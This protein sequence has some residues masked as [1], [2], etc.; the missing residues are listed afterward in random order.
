MTQDTFTSF[1]EDTETTSKPTT[2][3]NKK[4]KTTQYGLEYDGSV[5]GMY[6]LFLLDLFMRIITLGIYFFWG[7]TRLRKHVATHHSLGGDRFEYTGTGGELFKGFLKVLPILVILFAPILLAEFYPIL[8][9]FY[10]PL[11]YCW[12]IA[13]YGASRYRYSRLRWRGIRGFLDGSTIGYANLAFKRM[14]LNVITLG[15]TKPASDIAKY[16]YIANNT[17]FGSIK[18]EYN[19]NSK[20]LFGAY[21]MSGL[22]IIVCF[23]FILGIIGLSMGSV[24]NFLNPAMLGVIIVL[25]IIATS[26]V[27]PIARAIYTA[28]LMREKMRGLKIGQLRFMCTV[29]A[30]ALIKHRFV[31]LLILIF[32]I[33]LGFPYVIHRN[34]GFNAKHHIIMGDLN[35]FRTEQA[36]DHGLTSGEGLE[37][38]FDVDVGFI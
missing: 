6:K 2:Q 37:T 36:E 16:S 7:K 31:N 8:G 3:H 38:A 12:G 15:F 9:L 28:A 22:L 17:Y 4:L 35:A 32:T 20:V 27:F 18:A 19:G 1:E 29:T 11:I 30:G 10:I 33:G 24:S 5:G 14:L 23:S 34:I 13:I 25:A 26:L 21:I